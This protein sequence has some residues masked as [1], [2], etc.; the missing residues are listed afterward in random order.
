MAGSKK[1]HKGDLVFYLSGYRQAMHCLEEISI[2][3]VLDRFCRL[4][5]VSVNC[6]SICLKARESNDCGKI[7]DL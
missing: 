7:Q 4:N 6:L 2:G 5:G 1:Q 3:C